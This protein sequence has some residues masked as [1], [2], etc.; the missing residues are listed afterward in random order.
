MFRQDVYSA[1]CHIRKM[2]REAG[3]SPADQAIIFASI[4][5]L[6]PRQLILS[7]KLSLPTPQVSFMGFSEGCS[8]IVLIE[9]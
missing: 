2:V 4:S 3:G 6:R 7:L 5:K 8:V 9:T 1:S